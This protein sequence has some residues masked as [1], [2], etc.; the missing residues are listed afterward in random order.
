MDIEEIQN[1]LK[2]CELF[3]RLKGN[4][5]EKIASMCHIRAYDPGEYVFHQGDLG[6]RIYIIA[7]GNIFLER[8]INL[9]TRKGNAMIGVLGRGRAFGCWSSIIG[10]SHDLMS[11][12]ICKNA[13]KIVVMKGT[14]LRNVMLTDTELG[15]K[16]M[17]KICLLL[18]ERI[19]GAWG[20]M[21]N[22]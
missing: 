10:E 7:E 16:V 17:E 2:N 1:A 18:R 8:S 11:S 19:Q 15:F 12:A 14:D 4:D 21:E 22:I 6:S 5:I 9:G 3:D 20:A 13:V